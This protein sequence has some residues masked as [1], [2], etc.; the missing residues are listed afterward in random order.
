MIT[1]R[2]SASR[3]PLTW[4]YWQW[5]TGPFVKTAVVTCGFGHTGT[6]N[7]KIHRIAPDGM[8]S[9]SW[10]CPFKCPWHEFARL[11]GWQP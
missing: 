2:Q 11:D 1:L 5:G 8:L 9:P 10:V 4:D 7:P 3:E 6:A